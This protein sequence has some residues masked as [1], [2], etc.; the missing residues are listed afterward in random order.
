MAIALAVGVSACGSHATTSPRPPIALTSPPSHKVKA[1]GATIR[2]IEPRP[3]NHSAATIVARV[4][5]HGFTITPGAVGKP[6]RRGQGHLHFSLDNGRYDQP[7]YSGAA[8]RLA[9]RRGV[10]GLYSVTTRKAIVYRRVPLGRHVLR[11]SLANNDDTPAG[12]SATVV[13]GTR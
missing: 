12:P 4:Q 1:T 5:T 3:G 7:R 2:I 11:V 8:G 6:A 9:V 10:N 13:F